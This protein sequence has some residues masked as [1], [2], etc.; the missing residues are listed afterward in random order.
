MKPAIGCAT[1][2]GRDQRCVLARQVPPWGA[3][4]GFPTPQR[5]RIVPGAGELINDWVKGGMLKG[6]SPNVTLPGGTAIR[7]LPSG[8][9]MTLL[10][11]P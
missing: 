1:A 10:Q 8:A 7:S 6:N 11:V 2:G 5:H 3:G 4:K 9:T